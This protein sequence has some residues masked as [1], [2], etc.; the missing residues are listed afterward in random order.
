MKKP[1]I[2]ITILFAAALLTMSMGLNAMWDREGPLREEPPERSGD[3]HSFFFMADSDLFDARILWHLKDRLNLTA[4]QQEK[5]QKLVM[6]SETI[7]IRRGAEIKIKELRLLTYI[8]SNPKKMDRKEVEKHIRA[9][10]EE[11]TEMIIQY[12]NHLLDVKALLTPEQLEKLKEGRE[13][14]KKRY[15]KKKKRSTA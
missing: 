11:K 5:L 8:N 13:N 12:I 6:E 1:L 15:R 4:E 2:I 14:L 7:R 9:I 3:F 10:S